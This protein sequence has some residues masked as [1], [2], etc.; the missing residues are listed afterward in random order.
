[1]RVIDSLADLREWT[2]DNKTVKRALVPTMGA[3]HEGHLSLCD[4]AR[5]AVC[6]DGHVVVTIFVNPTQFGPNED[7]D[8]YPRQLE[9]DVEACEARRVDL[10]FAPPVDDI[11]FP[12]K[13][14][15]VHEAYIAQSLY[16]STNCAW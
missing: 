5:E 11:Y 13:S 1:M 14:V 15:V 4:R 6:N 8:A 12:D 7:L 10:V 2:L 16:E 3:L 9:A